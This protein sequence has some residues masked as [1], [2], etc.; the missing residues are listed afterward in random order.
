[1]VVGITM[2]GALVSKIGRH[3]GNLWE[4][5]RVLPRREKLAR[6]VGDLLFSPNS[7]LID[8]ILPEL[9]WVD[10]VLQNPLDTE[11]NL[12][13]LTLIVQTSHTDSTYDSVEVEIIKEVTL[14]AKETSSVS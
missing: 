9:F 1:M 3:F 12:S 11:V 7:A 8:C 6:T 13:N 10:L 14:G 2:S 4:A 5:K